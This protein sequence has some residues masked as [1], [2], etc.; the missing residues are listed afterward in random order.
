MGCG[1]TYVVIDTV[2]IVQDMIEECLETEGTLRKS[3]DGTKSILKFC[4]MYPNTMAGHIKFTQE[5]MLQY[6]VDNTVEW[7]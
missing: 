7:E 4:V 3:L 1:C 2:L 5:E 6:L